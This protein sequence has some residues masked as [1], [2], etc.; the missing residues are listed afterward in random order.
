[1]LDEL[2]SYHRW[3][4]EGM[5][6]VMLL[7]LL[8][9]FALRGQPLRMVFWVRVG[10]FAFWAFWTMGAF[11][12]LIA[13]MF[14]LRALPPRVIVMIVVALILPFLDGYRAIKLKSIWL[15]GADGTDLNS[16]I[17]GLEL[18]LSLS[19]LIYALSGT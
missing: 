3:A 16:R 8:I 18:L 7:N 13:W 11:A 15:A 4:V 6:V 12:G 14:T 17:V 19:V 2:I 5:A 9:P 1:M 10:Y